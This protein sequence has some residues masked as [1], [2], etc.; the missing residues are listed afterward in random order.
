[1]VKLYGTCCNTVF[2][3]TCRSAGIL[4][5]ISCSLPFGR[6][7]RELLIGCDKYYISNESLRDLR[8][9]LSL[10]KFFRSVQAVMCLSVI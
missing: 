8:I 1:M 10:R 9:D 5:N 2:S 3:N 7:K 4:L 6:T